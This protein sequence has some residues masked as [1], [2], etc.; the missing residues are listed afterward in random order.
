MKT[1]TAEGPDEH[2]LLDAVGKFYA[3]ALDPAAWEDA[4]ATLGRLVGADSGLLQVTRLPLAQVAYVGFGIDPERARTY[5]EHFAAVDLYLP[6]ARARVEPGDVVWEYE[7]IPP[8]QI[9]GTE[10]F[11][12]YL[13]P[14]GIF[15]AGQS[16]GGILQNDA[17]GLAFI[18]FVGRARRRCLAP[19]ADETLK[20]LLPH[21][22]RAVDI[23]ARVCEAQLAEATLDRLQLGVAFLDARG[24]VLRMSRAAAETFAAHDGL[25]LRREVLHAA[26]RS[27]HTALERLIAHTAAPGLGSGGPGGA[28][29]IRRPSGRP[30]LSLVAVPA[31]PAA[32]LF[33][34]I[35]GAAVLFIA[36]PEAGPPAAPA[37]TLSVLYGLTPGEAR[38]AL[39][40]AEGRAPKE[41]AQALEVSVD[42]VRTV[43]KRV[44]AK[45]GVDRQ[46]ALARLL[47]RTLPPLR[48]DE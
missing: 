23:Q 37:E 14:Q 34:G 1:F 28:L 7:V 25:E 8:D 43:L 16:L 48:R 21:I 17:R 31:S 45:T 5:L 38:T 20:V 35:L 30:P 44:F 39:L 3:A 26:S 19:S 22:R 46:A 32:T 11:E 41:V 13:R 24:R 6:A 36:D 42:T 10:I 12:D 27:E 4:V 2:A 9:A 29:P 18:Q 33:S 40:I 15:G 47:A